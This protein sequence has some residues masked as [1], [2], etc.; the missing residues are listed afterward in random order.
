MFDLSEEE[1][2]DFDPTLILAIFKRGLGGDVVECFDFSL[3]VSLTVRLP[4]VRG[5]L[6]L[7]ERPTALTIHYG[8][9]PISSSKFKPSDLVRCPEDALILLCVHVYILPFLPYVRPISDF[10]S[11]VCKLACASRR[12]SVLGFGPSTTFFSTYPINRSISIQRKGLL[13]NVSFINAHVLLYYL[14]QVVLC[15]SWITLCGALFLSSS[16]IDS[17][18]PLS[19]RHVFGCTFLCTIA[20]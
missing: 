18:I 20:G 16:G 12:A 2:A 15:G 4:V 8:F 1:S 9:K 14:S 6:E 3:S 5:I 19:W 7:L 10:I 13:R 11:E 17:P